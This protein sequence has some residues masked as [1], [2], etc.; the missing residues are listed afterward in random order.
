MTPFAPRLRD[1]TVATAA[2]LAVGFA[3]FEAPAQTPAPD[4]AQD[5]TQDGVA[6]VAG[7]RV[8]GAAPKESFDCV[9]EPAVVVRLGSP[10]GGI[11]ETVSVRRGQAVK[12]GGVV[13][14]LRSDLEETTIRLLAKRAANDSEVAAERARLALARS[15]LVRTRQLV[16]ANIGAVGE[17]EEAEAAVEVAA[18][19]VSMAETRQGISRIELE[20]A[21][22][23]LAERIITS[24]I[25]G[26]VVERM[27]FDG[28]F[29]DENAPIARIAQLDPLHVEAF[30]PVGRFKDLTVGDEVEVRPDEPI[31]GVFTGRI[32][33]IDRVFDAA[34]GTFGVQIEL[35]N[36]D[37]AVPAGHR[38]TVAF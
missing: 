20:R 36:P 8:P 18:R 5:E 6:D 29:A 30:L 32:S 23:A 31:E 15:Q 17:L 2:M 22:K 28:E 1:L 19:E 9:I 25:D 16:D 26:V 7:D 10:V 35:A 13:A 3:T 34:S 33:V 21:K 4:A 14:R 12:K 27:L 11:L 24:P 37:L 38:C